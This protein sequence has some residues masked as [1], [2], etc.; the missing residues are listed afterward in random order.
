MSSYDNTSGYVGGGYNNPDEMNAQGWGKNYGE[1]GG[2]ESYTDNVGNTGMGSAAYPRHGS[3]T[4]G[5]HSEMG[6]GT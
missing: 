2:T 5:S 4:F 3:N 1:Y 6:A